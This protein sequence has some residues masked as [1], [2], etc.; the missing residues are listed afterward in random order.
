[1]STFNES[2]PEAEKPPIVITGAKGYNGCT[3]KV[4][5]ATQVLPPW[6]IVDLD[7]GGRVVVRPGHCEPLAGHSQLAPQCATCDHSTTGGRYCDTCLPVVA[8]VLRG[9]QLLDEYVA[10]WQCWPGLN[11]ETLDMEWHG[12]CLLSQLFGSYQE[13]IEQLDLGPLLIVG[14][15][16]FDSYGWEHSFTI[17]PYTPQEQVKAAF[18]RLTTVWKHI[19]IERRQAREMR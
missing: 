6:Y 8:S 9:V 19:I 15:V 1:M 11:L 18:A 5:G 13:G 17:P 12:L 4:I 3:G 14:P 2:R 16:N 7:G 10:G